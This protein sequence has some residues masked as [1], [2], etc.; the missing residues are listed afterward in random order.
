MENSAILQNLDDQ[1]KEEIAHALWLPT[2][3][4]SLIPAEVLALLVDPKNSPQAFGQ[5]M[6]ARLRDLLEHPDSY[7]PS[8]RRRY[9]TMLAHCKALSPQQAYVMSM[10]LGLDSSRGFQEIPEAPD[11]QFPRDHAP[12]LKYQVGWH[13]YVGSCRGEDGQEYG[14]EFMIWQATLLPPPLAQS[15]GLTEMENQIMELH[16]AIS[17]A[18]GLHYRART[19]LVAGTTGLISFQEDPFLYTFGRNTIRSLEK[20]R[21]FPQELISKA[22]DLGKEK[23]VQLDVHLVFDDAKP[24]FLEGKNGAC[25]SVAGVGTLYYSIPRLHLDPAA[26]SLALDGMTVRLREGTFWFD[27]Q[28]CTG[29]APAGNPRVEAIR[30]A[31]NLSDPGPGGWDWFMAHFQNG[32]EVT[33]AAPHTEANKPFYNQSGPTPPGRMSASVEGKWI[34]VDGTAH[35]AWGTL[36]VPQWVQAEH[37]PDPGLYPVTQVWYP[38]RWEFQLGPEVP[39]S[40]RCFHMV[41]IVQEGQAGYF[42]NGSQYSEGAVILQDDQGKEIGRGFAE[43]VSYFDPTPLMLRLAGLPETP[44]M[45][46]LV[47][48]SATPFCLRLRSMLY[49]RRPDAQ[50]VLAHWAPSFP[51]IH[52]PPADESKDG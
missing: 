29:L 27:H 18:G 16:L 10:L 11:I 33:V 42:A 44:E 40:L 21:F 6:E 32:Q 22:W 3:D 52:K 31:K 47:G 2:W 48:P 24:P 7:T 50:A 37:S 41:P 13:F 17:V 39:E 15:L 26:S 8:Y 30:A 34:D 49:L 36:A 43:S 28:W 38:D 46:A 4:E 5:R 35:D 20:G 25:P 9:Q 19:S 23:P 12:Q 1:T 14:V 51:G 45:L